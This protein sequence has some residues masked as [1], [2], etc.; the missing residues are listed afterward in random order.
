MGSAIRGR[1]K[2]DMGVEVGMIFYNG[3]RMP[4]G[5]D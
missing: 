1:G 5:M 4:I 2:A 3:E